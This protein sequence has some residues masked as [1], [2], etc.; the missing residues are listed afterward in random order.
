MR[1]DGLRDLGRHDP[2]QLFSTRP[3]QVCDASEFPQQLLN[4]PWPD[5]WNVA[6]GRFRLPFSAALAVKADREAMRFVAHLLDGVQQPRAALPD[7]AFFFLPPNVQNLFF[8]LHS[9]HPM[10]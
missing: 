5:T 9:G 3:P 6:K 1:K 2:S 8:S 4:R 10:N 7:A